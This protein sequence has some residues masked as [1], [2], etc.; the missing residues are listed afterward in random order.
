MTSLEPF[1][2]TL[3]STRTQ[4]EDLY[5]WFHQHPELSSQE[6]DTAARIRAELDALGISWSA[7][8]GTGTVCVLENGEGP[9]V[10]LR[11]DIDALP[12]QETSG[13]DYASTATQVDAASGTEVATMHA[14]GHDMHIMSLLGALEAF[15]AHR[16]QWT[17]TLVGVFQP[18]E[19]TA[20]G[21]RAMVADNIAG[22]IPTPDVYLGQHVL[23][24]LPAGVVGSRPGPVLSQAFSSRV[25]V[26]GKGTHGSMPEMGV[27]P[28]LLAANIITRLH[29][30]VSREIAAKDTTVL[31]VG[32][33]QAGSKA[34][35]I[36]ES[37][38]LLINTRAYTAE[39]SAHLR[40]AIERIVRAECV[41]ARSPR[42][43]EFEYFDEYPL[44]HN[45]VSSTQRVRDAFDAHFGEQSVDLAQVPASEDFS[46]IPDALGVPYCYWG[47]G[48]FADP[49][50][51][52]G[53][54][55]PAFA[56]DMQPTLDRGAEAMI[57]A[58]FAWL[59]PSTPD[60]EA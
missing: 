2:S 50:T 51:A 53:N 44:T 30:V 28:V 9:V 27:D 56:P 24:S 45:D 42:E 20:S 41:A 12:V 39:D 54:H 1:L 18:A 36:P 58:A 7:V 43:P 40:S 21:A 5:R 25:T 29:T 33:V 19:E 59:A 8:G 13:K 26:W 47:L 22:V 6:T 23:P 49:S 11:A 52:P 55:S 32:A 60:G 4:R 14:C 31:T 17:G 34:N 10:A 35:V 3:A 48:G 15:H 57:V 38:E 16:E 37:A 46:V